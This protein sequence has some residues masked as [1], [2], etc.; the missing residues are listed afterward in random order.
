MV[1]DVG[2]K[3]GCA[4]MMGHPSLA[5]LDI[6]YILQTNDHP[7]LSAMTAYSP[8]VIA[9]N[10]MLRMQIQLT[11]QFGTMQ[12]RLYNSFNTSIE[13]S[14]QYTTLEDT[15]EASVLYRSLLGCCLAV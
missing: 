15:K 1:A 9:L 4:F 8:N 11:Q 12:Q 2:R 13:S 6:L 7:L 5:R 14:Y 3:D 10:D